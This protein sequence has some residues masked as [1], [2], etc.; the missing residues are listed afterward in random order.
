MIRII[1]VDDHIIFREGLKRVLAEN[2]DMIIISEAGDGMKAL[3]KLET[4]SCDVLLLDLALPG[5]DGLDVLRA[6]K[7]QK[8]DL[9]VLV[10]SMYP[11]EQYAVRVLKEGAAGY[12]V[13]ESVPEEL[14][15]AIRKAASGGQYISESL[16]Q[17]LARSLVKKD[18]APTHDSL[19]NREFQVFGMIT[20]GKTI[21][22]ISSELALS[23]TTITSYRSRILD[24]MKMN[25]NA[26]IIRYAVENHL[27]E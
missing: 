24:K 17:T 15:K 27:F 14:V 9:P 22:E 25:N 11:E 19:S 12:L 20:S 1:I 13:K 4:L 6:V 10:L 21:K 5:M 8:P 18:H 2:T 23:R 16:G 26:D 7:S 3:K